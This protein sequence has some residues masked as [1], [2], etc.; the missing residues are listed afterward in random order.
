MFSWLRQRRRQK[1]W[2]QPFPA[3]WEDVLQT[4]MG[5][6]P[7]LSASAREQVRRIARILVAEKIWEG[8]GGLVMTE[9]IQ[10]TIAGQAALL[11]L[12]MEHDYFARVLS[13][14]V[15]PMAFHLAKP[16]ET[17]DEA[18]TRD[19]LAAEGQ[20]VYRGPVILSWDEVLG[21]G[22][23]PELGHNV[24]VHEFA[25]QLDFLD[26][27]AD[28]VPPLPTRQLLQRWKKEMP[29]ALAAHR[30]ALERGEETFF[31]EHAGKDEAEFF[32]DASE[33]F[34]CLPEDLR[35]AFPAIYDLLA[36]YYRVDPLKWFSS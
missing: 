36:G 12:G 34:F 32:A 11:L 25:H 22:R 3:A 20:A 26:N 13:I 8:C 14:I 21:E 27:Q 5:H 29:Q 24:V 17:G 2:S 23:E 7:R 35:E 30:A 9:E 19:D 28:G 4:N 10:V 16:D 15:Y 31:T 33:A 1:L 6:Y 18:F